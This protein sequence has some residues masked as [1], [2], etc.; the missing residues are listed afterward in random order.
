MPARAG[1]GAVSGSHPER[2]ESNQGL[3]AL[4]AAGST[5][6][7]AGPS[8]VPSLPHHGGG[9]VGGTPLG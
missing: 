4:P 5:A 3:P 7:C 2:L 6:V 8:P 9:R 1:P